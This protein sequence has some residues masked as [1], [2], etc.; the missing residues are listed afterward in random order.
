MKKGRLLAGVAMFALATAVSACDDEDSTPRNQT[1]VV[2]DEAEEIN[3]DD[4]R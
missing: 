4:S 1:V 3:K 2:E